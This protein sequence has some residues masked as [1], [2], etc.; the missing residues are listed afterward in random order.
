M[1]YIDPMYEV[2][3]Y[4]YE[5]FWGG[6]T[7]PDREQLGRRLHSAGF[8]RG[9]IQQALHWLDG[10]DSAAQ[11]IR[12]APAEG[13]ATAESVSI[14]PTWAASPLSRR[15]YSAHELE[16]LGAEGIACIHFLEN[17]GALAPALREVVIDRALAAPESPLALD[18]LK[19]IIM[20]VYWRF[21]AD[22]DVLVLDELCDDA[23][24]RI[25]H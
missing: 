16:H 13:E 5:H 14:P 1:R 3:V 22:P 19:I 6:K 18:D 21:D 15:V 23:A 2:L 12:L 20:M 8:E 10:L 11:G 17:A 24:R 4:V 7:S 9:E 25:A